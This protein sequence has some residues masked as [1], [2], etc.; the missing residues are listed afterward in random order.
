VPHTT[1]LA[2][3]AAGF[4]C[5]SIPFGV[6]L[7]RS[8]GIDIRLHGSRN[9]GATNVGRVLG[10]GYG[11]ACFVL[12][13]LKGAVPVLVAWW[14]E[15][16][17]DP[18]NADAVC[19]LLPLVVLAAILGHIFSPWVGFK[20]GKGV[21]TSFG[22]LAAMWPLMTYP[23][24]GALAIWVLVVKTTRFVSVASMAAAISLPVLL[25]VRIALVPSEHRLPVSSYAPVLA[26]IALLAAL[27]VWKHR[28]NIARLRAGTEPR[29]GQKPAQPA[30]DH[31]AGT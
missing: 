22:A 29:V 1:W 6:L 4:L 19:V 18:G 3:I 14:M 20:G 11:Y 12:D 23:A 5:G 24:F 30:P 10:K 13:A 8:K 25:A 9:I 28:S 31:A 26:A 15:V 7:A 2:L 27:V 17:P 16:R 21:A